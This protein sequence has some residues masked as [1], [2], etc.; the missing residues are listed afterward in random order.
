MLARLAWAIVSLFLLAGSARA[1]DPP[2]DAATEEVQPEPVDPRAVKLQLMDGSVVVGKLSIEKLPIET[3]FGPLEVPIEALRGF[4]P[5]LTSHPELDRQS[6]RLIDQ[7]GS[8][9]FQEREKAQKELARL[10]AAVQSALEKHQHDADAERR[11]R[12][13]SLLDALYEAA[14]AEG[15]ADDGALAADVPRTQ[16][17]VETNEFAIAGRIAVGEFDVSSPYGP[18]KVKLADIRRGQRLAARR[19]EL[20]RT[21]SVDAENIIQRGWKGTEIRVERGDKITIAASGNL[22]MTPWGQGVVSTPDGG[23]NFGWYAVN[24]IP[25]GMLIATIG[26]NDRAIRVGSKASIVAPRSGQLRLAIAMPP[27][28][29]A[30]AF[31]GKYVAKIVV[32][33]K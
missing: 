17:V 32:E 13:Q 10:G 7:L 30:Q 2:A 11:S 27:E 15:D 9:D 18:L 33:P 5:G 3:A 12:V 22:A 19:P 29:A 8:V 4:T 20:R 21:I 16:D 26:N 14:E 6:F 1:A 23:P 24:T 28:Q 25:G 31:P